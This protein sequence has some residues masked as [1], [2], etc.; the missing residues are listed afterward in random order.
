MKKTLA[1]STIVAN[2]SASAKSHGQGAGREVGREAGRDYALNYAVISKALEY[3]HTHK[4]EQPSLEMVAKV[5]GLSEFHFQKLFKKWAGVSPKN[6]L[7]YLS[8]DHAK[9]LLPETTTLDATYKV[10]LSGT[11]RL[12]D[13]FVKIEGMT[14]GEFKEGG[15][16]LK[17][18]YSINES[19]FG[20]YLVAS[21]EKGIC[22]IIF[23]DEGKKRTTNTDDRDTDGA[24]KQALRDLKKLWP[25]AEIMNKKTAMHK[26]FE[27]FLKN[28]SNKSKVAGG[29]KSSAPT[30]S[31]KTAKIAQ[32]AQTAQTAKT[33]TKTSEEKIKLY[34]KG[35]S[36]QIKVW[37]ALLRIPE[38]RLTSY[39]GLAKDIKKPKANRAV[40][41]ALASNPIAYLIPCHRVIKTIGEIG[42]YH[43]GVPRKMAI[44]GLESAK[45]TAAYP[46]DYS[47]SKNY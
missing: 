45:F 3:I 27:I 22:N 19:K 7:Q 5:V 21:T 38:G 40:G 10:G 23:G 25:H 9:S 2:S 12:H 41:T 35:T 42:Q 30:H 11:G 34:I 1:N 29:K 20:T 26:Q 43:W 31:A 17:I 8:I 32:T 18:F 4:R 16:N 33:S 46:V 15:K 6:F 36:F 14:P 44:I 47:F 39:K 37:E 24:G 13:L 28:A